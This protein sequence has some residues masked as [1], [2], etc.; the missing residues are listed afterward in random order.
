MNSADVINSLRS[1]FVEKIVEVTDQTLEIWISEGTPT[2]TGD[3]SRRLKLTFRDYVA[4]SV[5]N[6]SFVGPD[7]NEEF[8]GRRFR[9]FSRS[10]FLDYLRN[11]VN[12]FLVEHSTEAGRMQHFGLIGEDHIV[13]IATCRQFEID[14]ITES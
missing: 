4:Y 8:S 12:P 2:E 13:D 14:E 1:V 3:S 7:K 11:A 10:R 6:E 5:R 9:V